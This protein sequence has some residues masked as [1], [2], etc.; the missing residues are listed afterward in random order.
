MQELGDI[1]KTS[2]L[3]NVLR[4]VE[5]NLERLQELSPT[6]QVEQA[7][8]ACQDALTTMPEELRYRRYRR[9]RLLADI[10]YHERRL[11][12]ARRRDEIQA[13]RP[14]GCW[15]L[16]LGGRGRAYL[17]ADS[18]LTGWTYYCICPEAATTREAV[19]A[20][21]DRLNLDW[22]RDRDATFRAALWAGA[23][24]PERY[25]DCTLDSYPVSPGTAPILDRLRAWQQD[26]RRWWLM[27]WG[28]NGVGK[29]GLAVSLLRAAAD[30]GRSVLFQTMPD[31]LVLI[32]S[33]YDAN[34]LREGTNERG[35]MGALWDI[36]LLVVDDA[37]KE[38][39]TGWV[40]ER[41][42]LIFNRRHGDR[43]QTIVTSKLSPAE[44]AAK[45]GDDAGEDIMWRIVE[46]AGYRD[47]GED[48]YILH[49][50]GPN[51]RGR[52]PGAERR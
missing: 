49:V 28:Q 50:E 45:W 37:G 1:L 48:N 21:R 24:V 34:G 3:E 14:P 29:T 38:R 43:R 32:R 30:S 35:V 12:W 26:D 31:L 10:A 20:E 33:T 15:C 36:D 46:A 2:G 52:L 9:E 42:F 8:Q 27:L 22:V 25:R 41:L 23:G 5:P 17:A 44:L 39:V 18:D 4:S 16:G 51:L 19:A 47:L 7:L 13:T 11:A 6:E 40:A